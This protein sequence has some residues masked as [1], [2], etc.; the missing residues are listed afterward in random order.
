MQVNGDKTFNLVM[1]A[2]SHSHWCYIPSI[3]GITMQSVEWETV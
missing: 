2:F 3:A 1:T